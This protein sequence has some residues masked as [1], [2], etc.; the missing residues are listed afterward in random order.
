MSVGE[1][2]ML[3]AEDC[4]TKLFTAEE[5]RDRAILEPD[6]AEPELIQE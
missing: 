6:Q 3:L 2:T 1:T 4:L 5:F